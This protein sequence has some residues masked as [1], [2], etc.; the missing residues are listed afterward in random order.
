MNVRDLD[1]ETR[2]L[3]A[4]E[5]FLHAKNREEQYRCSKRWAQLLKRRRYQEEIKVPGEA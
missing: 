1:L 2:I 3:V 4:Y 5:E